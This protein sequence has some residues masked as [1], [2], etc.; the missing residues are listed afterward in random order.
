MTGS[1]VGTTDQ[2][3]QWA[4][5]KWGFD[6]DA[7][8]AQA[9]TE[10]WWHQDAMG[11]WTTDANACAPGHPLGADGRAGQC[12]ESMGIMQVRTQ[13]HRDWIDDAI[14][15]TAYN[16]D[17]TYAIMRSCYEGYETWLNTVERGRTYAAG[18][19]W[20]CFGRW[21]AGRCT[22]NPPSTTSPSSRTTTTNASG[23][24]PASSTADA[25]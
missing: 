4:A 15:S 18:D 5:C 25:W 3:L 17:I 6:E 12:P 2:I 19:M 22:P 13:Y 20:G 1:Y 9:A 14:A 10:S 24:P 23:P 8:R 11:D 21:L 16:V 7:I